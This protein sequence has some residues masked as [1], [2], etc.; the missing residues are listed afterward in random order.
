MTTEIQMARRLL[1]CPPTDADYIDAIT[2]AL[3]EADPTIQ[4]HHAAHHEAKREAARVVLFCL[5]PLVYREREAAR[6]G[7]MERMKAMLT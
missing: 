7:A 5:R 6:V 4:G 3:V 2:W 1:T